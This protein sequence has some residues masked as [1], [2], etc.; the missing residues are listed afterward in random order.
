MYPRRTVRML[1]AAVAPVV[2]VVVLA[3]GGL[4]EK[5]RVNPDAALSVEFLK[6]V[7]A[8]VELH[9]KVEAT[10]P[11]R[12]ERGTPQE[13]TTYEESLAR[14]IVAARSSARPGDLLSQKVR[15]YFRRQ[16]GGVLRGPDGAAIR[17]SVLEEN[18]GKVQLRVNARY[19]DGVP[20]STVPSQILSALP[21]LPQHIEYRFIG[22][23][24][25]L[26]DVHSQLVVDYMTDALPS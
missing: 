26:L 11:Q 24:L 1:V 13:I 21:K 25:L 15:S 22:D 2:W 7:E 4:Q 14:L 18:P 3:G 17:H 20:L 16:I 12:P 9:K 6:R 19:P 5:L 8:Y 10:L 23:R